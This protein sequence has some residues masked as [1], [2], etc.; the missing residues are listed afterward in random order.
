MLMIISFDKLNANRIYHTMTQTLIPRPI[1]WVLT[2]NDTSIDSFN[3]APFSYFTAISSDPAL[4]LLSIGKKAYGDE[5][6]SDKDTLH[7]LKTQQKCVIHIASADHVDALNTSAKALA[8]GESEIAQQ[9]LALTNFEGFDLPRLNGVGIAFACQLHQIVPID[10]SKQTMVLLQVESVFVDDALVEKDGNDR[11]SI[12]AD[13][14]SPLA[15]LGAG[16]Y[17]VGGHSLKKPMP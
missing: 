9:K 2:R 14:V 15:K 11:L 17:W 1:A 4:L 12:N 10:D 16:E 6:G 7:N 3:L 8:Y 13:N 5:V